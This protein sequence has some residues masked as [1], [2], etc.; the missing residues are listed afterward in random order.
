MRALGAPG[1]AVARRFLGFL[2]SAMTMT[3]PRAVG[4]SLAGIS[5]RADTKKLPVAFGVSRAVVLV[6]TSAGVPAPRLGWSFGLRTTFQATG[7]PVGTTLGARCRSRAEPRSTKSISPES[8][9]FGRS[10]SRVT[11]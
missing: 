11:G 6:P 4:A 5:R 2:I 8:R 3:M 1:C 9:K 7:V 10:K